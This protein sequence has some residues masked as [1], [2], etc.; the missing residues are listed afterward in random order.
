V[1]ASAESKNDVPLEASIPDSA[2][3]LESILRTEELRRRPSRPP[4]YAKENRALVALSSALADSPR[5]ILQATGLRFCPVRS[6]RGDLSIH[7]ASR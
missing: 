1:I 5:I 6:E 4:D 3:P 2:V 7:L